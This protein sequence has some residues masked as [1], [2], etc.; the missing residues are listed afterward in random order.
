M[1]KG[2]IYYTVLQ[3]PDPRMGLTKLLVIR[4][5]QKKKKKSETQQ[6]KEKR[7][8][9]REG[10]QK[11]WTIIGSLV[12]GISRSTDYETGVWVG[13]YLKNSEAKFYNG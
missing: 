11:P 12:S 2:T 7:D 4:V 9:A 1:R 6:E 5:G 3:T 13:F 8:P 10:A